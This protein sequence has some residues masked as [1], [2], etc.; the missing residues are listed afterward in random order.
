MSRYPDPPAST[1]PA[2]ASTGSCSGV[3]ARA[4][5][6]RRRAPSSTSTRPAPPSATSAA[7]S[8]AAR[9]TVW[10]VPSTGRRTACRAASL[11]AVRAC[12][13][14]GAD[15]SSAPASTPVKPRSSCERITPELP[16][17]PMSEPWA[18]AWHT[19]AMAGPPP[20]DEGATAAEERLSEERS[21]WATSVPGTDCSSATTD[22]TVSAML[23]PVSPSGTG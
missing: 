3:W 20:L 7:P 2:R 9:A 19:S 17:A 13:N 12:D 16:R 15:T 4:S 21:P 8:P 14:T 6:A 1:T 5:P 11:A 18:T 23:V 10:M 22:S